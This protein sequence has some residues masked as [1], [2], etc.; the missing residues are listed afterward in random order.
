MKNTNILK[1]AF[2]IYVYFKL[3]SFFQLL[4]NQNLE[5]AAAFESPP[6]PP[7]PD[8]CFKGLWISELIFMS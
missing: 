4:L 1:K 3:E 5:L 2:G 7:Q 6:P 8:L